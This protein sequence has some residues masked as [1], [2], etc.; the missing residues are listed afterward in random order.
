MCCAGQDDNEDQRPVIEE[1]LGR[2]S[3]TELDDPSS[4]RSSKTT[5]TLQSDPDVTVVAR[6]RPSPQQQQGNSTPS[7]RLRETSQ[8]LEVLYVPCNLHYVT[9]VSNQ[10]LALLQERKSEGCAND[11]S[12][13]YCI[14]DT[15][16]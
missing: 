9:P 1:H 5:D 2:H 7:P 14:A 8:R 6:Q 4:A 13:R 3:D 16:N 15:N 12:Y 11:A 10:T